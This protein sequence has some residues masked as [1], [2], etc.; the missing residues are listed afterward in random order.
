MGVTVAIGGYTS[1]MVLSPVARPEC[2][3]RKLWGRGSWWLP[4][5]CCSQDFTCALPTGES[6]PLAL[7]LFAF[8][9]F[10][11]ILVVALLSVWKMGQ[12]LRYSCCPAVVLPDTLVRAFLYL[13]V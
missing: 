13:S 4:R 7:A 11:L 5:P 9:G 1:L 6:L 12:L 2:I 10:V 8:V 3:P